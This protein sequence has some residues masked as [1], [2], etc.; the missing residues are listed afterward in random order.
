MTATR[1]RP[2]TMVEEAWADPARELD[3]ASARGMVDGS[4]LLVRVFEATG[5]TQRQLAKNAGVTEG[6]VSQILSG[7][8]N[9]RLST[10]SR[11]LH[12]MGYQLTLSAINLADGTSI[13]ARQKK[14]TPPVKNPAELVRSSSH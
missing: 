7:E 12:A 5:M 6:R 10:V 2:S 1:D 3:M 14:A 8:E 11:Y 4:A 9:L 13:E